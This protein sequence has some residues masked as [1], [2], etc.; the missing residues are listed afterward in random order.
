MKNKFISKLILSALVAVQSLSSFSGVV[1]A[2]DS[3][4]SQEDVT[5]TLSE[6]V[7]SEVD[8]DEEDESDDSML[9]KGWSI[10]YEGQ[11]SDRNTYF[12]NTTEDAHF[13]SGKSMYVKYPDAAIADTYVELISG[14]TSP[15]TEDEEY[16]ISFYLKGS[17]GTDTEL[18]VGNRKIMLS[19]MTK[20]G[21]IDASEAPSGE[22]NWVKYSY[23]LSDY[24]G[25]ATTTLKFRIFSRTTGTYLDDVSIV[26][27]DG[28]N[29]I[30]DTSFDG[31]EEITTEVEPFD[32]T[33]YQA[34][35]MLASP[36][37]G[38]VGLSWRNPETSDLS[39][40]SV[41]NL[42]DGEEELIIDSLSTVP[43][44]VVVYPVKGI[45]DGKLQLFLIRFDYENGASF[46]YYMSCT[47]GSGTYQGMLGEWNVW[48]Y[49]AGTATYTPNDIKLD[50]KEFHS[51]EAS[52]KHILNLDTADDPELK[53][54]NYTRAYLGALT[55]DKDLTYE[56]KMWLKG[57]NVGQFYV[58]NGWGNLSTGITNGAVSNFGDTK[59]WNEYTFTYNAKA[60]GT[61]T[62]NMLGETT[63]VV[64]I[65]DVSIYV[66]DEDGN[67]TGENLVKDG[68]FEGLLDTSVGDLE[69]AYI[70]DIKETEITLNWNVTSSKVS[71]V[72]IYENVF[73][74]YEYR[75]TVNK[76]IGSLKVTGLA[77]GAEYSYKLVPVNSMGVEGDG[78][79]ITA[80]TKMPEYIVK[81]PVLKKGNF[82]VSEIEEAGSYSVTSEVNNYGTE[83]MPYLQ[84]VAVYKDGAL[85][86]IYP[87][88][89]AIPVSTKK[90]APQKVT[91]GFSIEGEGNYSVK[92]YIFDNITDMNSYI[93]KTV[94][95]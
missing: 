24:E 81:T 6:Y 49:A 3:A 4:I 26:G 71:D 68:G 70:T 75:G 36:G 47:S 23:I 21:R 88:E 5:E 9:G 19:D 22:R 30:T 87:T 34:T 86:K 2:S 57:D 94:F 89:K 7:P 45:T 55:A 62:L 85:E 60:G 40:V 93:P 18:Y 38:V 58:K 82:A 52:L 77:M 27:S 41:Y 10:K 46:K 66:L 73:G 79:E 59:D 83:N 11:K 72:N 32:T 39:K 61:L 44:D 50:N 64:W 13:S 28:V 35:R 1:F 78:V 17:F 56:I 90:T 15:V 8:T 42:T 48:E 54:N 84:C 51:G 63:G 67:P 69:K 95:E 91:T 33:A 25:A 53:G 37:K 12:A 92:V 14:M 31:I 74:N 80:E 65:D 76:G 16:E 20:S 29:L 43:G